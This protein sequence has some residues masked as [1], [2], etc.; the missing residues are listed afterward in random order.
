MNK[1]ICAIIFI[2]FFTNCNTN[3]KKS[4]TLSIHQFSQLMISNDNDRCINSISNFALTE[5]TVDQFFQKALM[6]ESQIKSLKLIFYKEEGEVISLFKTA[7]LISETETRI[8]YSLNDGEIKVDM[9]ND[10]F[11]LNDFMKGISVSSSPTNN[12]LLIINIEEKEIVCNTFMNIKSL[13]TVKDQLL[14]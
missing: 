6:N 9:K 13:K 11:Y 14:L 3:S 8:K 2:V 5:K 7:I 12:E 1:I 4:N 10:E